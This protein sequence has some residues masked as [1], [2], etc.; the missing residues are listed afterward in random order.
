ME[1]F[2]SVLL[3]THTANTVE[4]LQGGREGVVCKDEQDI[5]LTLPESNAER[6]LRQ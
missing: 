5:G 4:D 2:L 3:Y 6:Q 1:T